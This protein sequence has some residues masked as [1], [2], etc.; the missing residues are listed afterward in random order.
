[1]LITL[2]L[3][4][5]VVECICFTLLYAILRNLKKNINS[6]SENTLRLQRQLTLLLFAQFLSPL[7]YIFVPVFICIFVILNDLG[8]SEFSVQVGMLEIECYAFMNSLLT[9]QFI[10]PY[11]KHFISVVSSLCGFKKCYLPGN[12]R[13]LPVSYFP[14]QQNQIHTIA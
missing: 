1:M 11:R 12:D 8:L 5:I 3:I 6:F 9:I 7:L 10:S 13:I 4:F 14:S 2:I